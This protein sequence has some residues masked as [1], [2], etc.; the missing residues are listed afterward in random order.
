MCLA[1]KASEMSTDWTQAPRYFSR[2]LAPYRAISAILAFFAV[3]F[4]LLWW[5]KGSQTVLGSVFFLVGACYVF[6]YPRVVRHMLTR[7]VQ[8]SS[9]LLC[10]CC[11]YDLGGLTVC[12]CPECGAAF[13][14][15][16]VRMTWVK[17][18]NAQRANMRSYGSEPQEH[19]ETGADSDEAGR[20]A[21]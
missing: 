21:E 20:G 4:L 6:A 5:F 9:F 17:W 15:V 2:L 11:G 19:P 3:S 18:V 12:C 13:D 14:P 7:Q 1:M 10:L 16:E 8:E